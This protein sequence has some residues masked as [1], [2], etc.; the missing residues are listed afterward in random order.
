MRTD[1][2]A[3]EIKVTGRP[4]GELDLALAWTA[5]GFQSNLSERHISFSLVAVHS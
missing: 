5:A 4:L 1:P 3:A 2:G